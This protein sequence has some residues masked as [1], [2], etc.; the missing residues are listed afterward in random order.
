[1]MKN[2]Y[3]IL[4]ALIIL[5]LVLMM[6][7]NSNSEKVEKQNEEVLSE[8]TLKEIDSLNKSIDSL[9]VKNNIKFGRVIETKN[10]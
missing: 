2:T 7:K 8:E 4:G 6:N 1:M 5:G 3:F 9:T 10:R